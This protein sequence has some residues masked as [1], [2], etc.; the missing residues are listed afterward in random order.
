MP[1]IVSGKALFFVS[2][3]FCTNI[4]AINVHFMSQILLL[5]PRC[6]II[7][8]ISSFNIVW[9][10][11]RSLYLVFLAISWGEGRSQNQGGG[12]LIYGF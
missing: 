3:N 11:T 4:F 6:V 8:N 1:E 10:R 9:I 7:S 2:Q 12:G 5:L